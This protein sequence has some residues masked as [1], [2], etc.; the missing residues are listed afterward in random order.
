MSEAL[1]LDPA[2]VALN[3]TAW[4]V[5]QY[6]GES[7][8]DWG[9]AAIEQFL[10]DIESGSLPVD[11]RIPNRTVQIPLLLLKS[12]TGTAY[13]FDQVR[14]RFQQKAALF[15]RKG[16]WISRQTAVGTVYAD[17]IG[18]QLKLGGSTAQA[19]WGI[20]ADAI[21]TL[22]CLPDWY[23]AEV[24]AGTFTGATG[25]LA[26]NVGQIAGDYPARARIIVK[27]TAT[28]RRHGLL[29]AH[30]YYN[31][32]STNQLIYNAY[33]MTLLNGAKR[34]NAT[35]G[36]DDAA[37]TLVK[38]GWNSDTNWA[39]VLSTDLVAGPLTHEGS[40]R[41][42]ARVGIDNTSSGST[43]QIRLRWDVGDFT[44]ATT[45][46]FVE[47]PK[48][49]STEPFSS[50][51][52]MNLVDLGEIRL[53]ASPIG[54]H[55]WRGEIQIKTRVSN[56]FFDKI[57]ITPVDTGYGKLIASDI[58]SD[59]GNTTYL[60]TFS[61]GT[62]G[63]VLQGSGIS[64]IPVGHTWTTSGASGDFL[65]TRE[66][67]SGT[68]N[69]NVA[70]RTAGVGQRIAYA[71]A[72]VFTA[73]DVQIDVNLPAILALPSYDVSLFARYVDAT[74]NVE[75]KF[76]SDSSDTWFQVTVRAT[77]GATGGRLIRSDAPTWPR[78][79]VAGWV[80]FRLVID[81]TGRYFA[82]LVPR[83]TAFGDPNIVGYA[84]ILATGGS[85]ASGVT[86][87]GAGS[88]TG[89]VMFDNFFAKTPPTPDAAIYEGRGVELRFDS[90]Y[91]DSLDGI[92][93]GQ[94]GNII[95]DLCRLPPSGLE[96]RAVELLVKPTRGDFGQM[97]DFDA[98]GGIT[99]RVLYRPCY[100]FVP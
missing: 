76:V 6:V 14:R 24:D 29:W 52:G 57:F 23:G 54:T 26:A 36:A 16:G 44:K 22:T 62:I 20:D 93:S 92:G 88:C 89:A 28:K 45:N 96:A 68:G 10:A 100:L 7:G 48:S 63:A 53:D 83:G 41:V 3:R 21:L 35:T 30:R 8:P 17:V 66:D 42:W 4:D 87:F 69:P 65:L 86:G 34:V 13:T 81:T 32:A 98:A 39:T 37:G 47:V 82:W 73:V 11:F 9:D 91:R 90:M 25:D 71:G 1:V 95:G 31:A 38:A 70:S 51:L 59:V 55:R 58:E 75:C 61:T 74:N 27:D 78:G 97:P 40:Y 60:T 2:A 19:L 94:V 56:F 77:S 79:L 43:N 84:P 33:N 50:S 72:A 12:T 49:T 15:Q 85:L 64:G 80:T 46:P 5:T 99:A 18:A 67:G